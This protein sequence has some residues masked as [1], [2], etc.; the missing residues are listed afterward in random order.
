ML[1]IETIEEMRA[2]SAAQKK[3]GNRIGFVPTM[4]CL[5]DGHLSLVN[6]A[7]QQN[8]TVV[9]S[10]F[11]NPLQ[12][13]ASEDYSIYPRTEETDHE[14]AAS[15]G[16]DVVFQPGFQEMYPVYPPLTT[17]QVSGITDR[18]C[19]A[20]RHG[21]FN[22]VTTVVC[23]LFQIV[24]PDSA[25]FGQKDYQ[26]ALVI[27]RMARDLDL[28]VHVQMAPIIREADGLAMSSRNRYL[29]ESQRRE[30]ICLS[31]ALK[32]AKEL[33]DTG[34]RRSAPILEAMI[35][36]IQA[37]PSAVIDYVELC[38]LE[39]LEPVEIIEGPVVLALAVFF[40]KTRLIDNLILE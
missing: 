10:I 28:P 14:L 39:N 11:V 5:H 23:K 16:V 1:I 22:G 20:S 36:R 7:R 31:Q 4:G 38:D 9:L 3:S 2:W 6:I 17:V 30:A 35:K 8:Q 27:R 24:A 40:G 21:H 32:L 29:T 13:G 37:S 15:A 12:F 26:Q 18:L 34:E 25:Y 19:G 33:F